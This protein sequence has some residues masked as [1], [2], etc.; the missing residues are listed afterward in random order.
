[1]EIL[2]G[3]PFVIAIILFGLWVISQCCQGV[4]SIGRTTN[5]IGEW[6]KKQLGEKDAC[7]R[8]NKRS[9]RR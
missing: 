8:T 3:L 4:R 2:A 5:A 6:N 1:M 9:R 7:S